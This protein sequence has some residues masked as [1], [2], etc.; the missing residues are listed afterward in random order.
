MVNYTYIP[1]ELLNKCMAGAFRVFCKKTCFGIAHNFPTVSQPKIPFIPFA[2]VELRTV[3]AHHTWV[4]PTGSQTCV[5]GC[6]G[7]E[8][9]DFEL[10]FQNSITSNGILF[11]PQ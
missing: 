8:I 10:L 5:G 6:V 3:L 9:G 7:G 1:P 11:G 4:E 2:L